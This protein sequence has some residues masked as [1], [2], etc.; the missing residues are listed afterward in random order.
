[1]RA[2]AQLRTPLPRACLWRCLPLQSCRLDAR[3]TR[4]PAWPVPIGGP[5]V[6]P[7]LGHVL[8]PCSAP[9]PLVTGTPGA[10]GAKGT[11]AEHA[12]H[13]A[14][15]TTAHAR[16]HTSFCWVCA[17]CAACVPGSLRSGG[18]AGGAGSLPR[19]G[20]ASHGEVSKS[21]SCLY[22]WQLAALFWLRVARRCKR[23]SFWL[24]APYV[25]LLYS[26]CTRVAVAA[27]W[28]RNGE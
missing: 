2:P 6:P 24:S 16:P 12:S 11:C 13:W 7:A 23:L 5:A 9:V 8:L 20:G 28:L 1:M 25:T 22:S 27:R 10:N 26:T 21:W 15:R 3:V 4:Y 14:S 19:Q 17:R 18:D